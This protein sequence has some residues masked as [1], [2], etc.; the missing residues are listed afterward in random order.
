[1]PKQVMFPVDT[2]KQTLQAL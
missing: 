2:L 1:V